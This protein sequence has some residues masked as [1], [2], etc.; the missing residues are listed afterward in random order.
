MGLEEHD[1]L[2][3]ADRAWRMQM[4]LLLTALPL[5][6][7]LAWRT[8]RRLIAQPIERLEAGVSRLTDGDFSAQVHPEDNI[9][10][11]RRLAIAFNGLSA[12]LTDRDQRLAVARNDLAERN[13]ELAVANEDLARFAYAASHDLRAPL[14]SMQGLLR[15]VCDQAH[16]LD[17]EERAF[18]MQ[19]WN[20]TLR[21]RE[22][23]D[24][25]VHIA[26]LA[27]TEM[28]A[29]E[30]D[31]NRVA[32]NA[33]DDLQADMAAC[34]ATVQLASLPTVTCNP[35]LIGQVMQNLLSNAIK[36]RREGVPPHVA[37]RAAETSNA[38]RVEVADN[39]VGIAAD[40]HTRIFDMF[41]R[42]HSCRERDGAGLGLTL[43][44]KIVHR[45][46]GDIGVTSQ[47][48]VGSTFWFTL[49]K[50]NEHDR[51]AA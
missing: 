27:D 38:W 40:D 12:A 8:G 28:N 13:Q 46:G 5:T 6:V 14:N 10:E 41:Q 20:M 11:L 33:L 36:F 30:I 15:A 16:R 19:A 43:C 22:L 42:L 50:E 1:A 47:P 23:A 48:G 34:A 39:G 31:L 4:G 18:L 3:A 37:I 24:A 7:L 49:P 35:T 9:A 25:V 51:H 21:M 45:H 26:A 17:V 44:Q 29:V 2:I 32:Q